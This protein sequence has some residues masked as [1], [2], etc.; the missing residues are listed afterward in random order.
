MIFSVNRTGLSRLSSRQ[1]S[2]IGFLAVIVGGYI[3][4]G[5]GGALFGFGLAALIAAQVE[6][7]QAS[8]IASKAAGSQ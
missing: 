5:P 3:A 8:I 6:E 2:I 4:W 7:I 1:R